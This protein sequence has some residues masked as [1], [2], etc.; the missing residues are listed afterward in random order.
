MGD[1]LDKGKNPKLELDEDQEPES[2]RSINEFSSAIR[3]VYERNL[4]IRQTGRMPTKDAISKTK[5]AAS[6][7]VIEEFQLE[8]DHDE[9]PEDEEAEDDQKKE[10]DNELKE[11]EEDEEEEEEK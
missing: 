1:P 6:T 10:E 7:A 8:E 2:E 4:K 5:G 9:F 11:E 3:H